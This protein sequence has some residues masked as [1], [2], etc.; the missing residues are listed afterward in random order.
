MIF[1]LFVVIYNP[2]IINFNLLHII[3]AISW[4]FLLVNRD[5]I[6]KRICIRK[7]QN[8][9][10]IFAAFMIYLGMNAAI[11]GNSITIMVDYF[12]MIFEIIPFCI[13]VVCRTR[14]D[15]QSIIYYLKV[16]A[17]LQACLA[18][19]AFLVPSIKNYF[20]Q[21]LI[22]YGYGDVILS[23]TGY[24]QNGFASS[25]ASYASFF[26]AFI[27]VVCFYA[28]IHN[29]KVWINLGAFFIIAF[30]AIINARTSIVIIIIGVM[31]ILFSKTQNGISGMVGKLLI[32]LFAIVALPFLFRSIATSSNETYKWVFDGINDIQNI[33][34]GNV[35]SS[36]SFFYYYKNF[37]HLPTGMALIF[38]KGSIIM[39]SVGRLKYGVSSDIGFINDIWKGGILYSAVLWLGFVYLLKRMTKTAKQLN[40]MT[41]LFLLRFFGV[42][43]IIINL[44]G[45][46]FVKEAQTIILMLLFVS[47]ECNRGKTLIVNSVEEKN[48]NGDR[49]HKKA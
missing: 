40:N 43:A 6:R 3:A 2:P 48:I 11:H 7:L 20:N 24:R 19:L 13:Y 4:L 35:G 45:F 25:L 16:V 46:F 28:V 15:E 1:C 23:M 5:E 30:S 26:Q 9:S 44:K 39:G 33:L 31:I 14:N 37:W 32:I 36:N 34:R 17:G 18:T 12:Y 21:R 41:I 38:G 47:L 27:A 22:S 49:V 29:K 42:V 10:L 8:V